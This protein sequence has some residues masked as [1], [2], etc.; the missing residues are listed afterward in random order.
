M[1][2]SEEK[3]IKF[4]GDKGAATV[5]EWMAATEA[6]GNEK[7]MLPY[8]FYVKGNS[9]YPLIRSGKDAVT[10]LRCNKDTLK[11]GD[12][13]LFRGH[14]YNLD[15]V[16]H[17][18][19]RIRGGQVQTLG[20]GNLWLDPWIEKEKICGR[21]V[22][23]RRG[24]FRIIPQQFIWRFP[25]LLWMWGYRFRRIPIKALHKFGDWKNKWM[26]K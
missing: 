17:R 13:I 2:E 24:S 19:Y 21:V 25:V 3:K 15:Y 4:Q 18:I 5:E 10:I 16:L 26:R 11:R 14:A 6:I 22:E 8:T 23:I 12:I 7:E 20:D 1:M 9:M